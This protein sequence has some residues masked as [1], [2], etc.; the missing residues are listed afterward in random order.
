MKA[1]KCCGTVGRENKYSEQRK[2]SIFYENT[3]EKDL[4]DVI[5]GIVFAFKR[6]IR[7]KD[8]KKQLLPM[9]TSL[10]LSVD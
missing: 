8:V 1:F 6:G 7:R 4:L 10:Y 2:K 9:N 5:E 3:K